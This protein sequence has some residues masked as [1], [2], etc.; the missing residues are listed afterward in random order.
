MMSKRLLYSWERVGRKLFIAV[1]RLSM[2][3]TR[4]TYIISIST[5]LWKQQRTVILCHKDMFFTT[6]PVDPAKGQWGRDIHCQPLQPLTVKTKR[7]KI[8][9]VLVVDINELIYNS[10]AMKMCSSVIIPRASP[11]LYHVVMSNLTIFGIFLQIPNLATSFSIWQTKRRPCISSLS[12]R[13]LSEAYFKNAAP[14]FVHNSW[15]LEFQSS[16]SH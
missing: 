5:K 7:K 9:I 4:R 6:W 15:Q 13:S 16:W 12:G 2:Y 14:V 8:Q 3:L 11:R 1:K 10:N